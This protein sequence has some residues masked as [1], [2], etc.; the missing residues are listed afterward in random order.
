MVDAPELEL[1]V[2]PS[3][4]GSS[5]YVFPDGP[6][7]ARHLLQSAPVITKTFVS[8]PSPVVGRA[9]A[10]GHPCQGLYHAPAGASP[11]TAFIATHY[12]VDFSEH[13]LAELLAERGYGFLGW[14]T[15]FRGAEPYFLLDHALAEIAVGVRWLREQGIERVV[16]LGNS[17]G[18]SLMSAYHS[19]CGE[20][21]IRP[22]WGRSLLPAV[23][24]LVAG[25]PVRVRRRPPRAPGDPHRLARPVAARR[26][27]TRSAGTPRSTCTTRPTGRR[28]TPRSSSATGPPRWPATTG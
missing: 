20:V 17:G 24:D 3:H 28:T 26:R 13:Y 25:R 22:P 6:A 1:V 18:G 2:G 23:H 8:A 9:G 19:Q 14:N 5:S 12:N 10:G 27:S 4:G 21:T 11:T 7:Y 16:L 15:R